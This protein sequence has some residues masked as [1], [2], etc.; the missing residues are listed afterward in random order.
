MTAATTP[1]L[2][3]V[4]EAGGVLDAL[5]AAVELRRRAVDSSELVPLLA[6]LH[7]GDA[8]ARAAAAYS[9]GRCPGAAVD[10]ALSRS[11]MSRDASVRNA[12]LLALSGRPSFPSAIPSLHRLAGRGGLGGMLA[13]LALEE[14]CADGRRPRASAVDFADTG[15]MSSRPSDGLRVA[16]VFLQ[17]R[18]DGALRDAGAG[19]GGGLATLVV[20]LSRALGR[21]PEIGHSAIITRAFADH[22]APA[23]HDLLHEPIGD[24]ASI[25]RIEFGPDGYLATAD[26]W[27]YRGEAEE[28][29]EA[30]FN[31]LMPL[32]VVHLRFADVGTFAAA[33]VCARLGIPVCFTV[34]AD[35]HVVIR[36]AER[37]GTL[38]RETFA[39]A[40]AGEHYLFRIHLVESMLEQA[41]GL[42]LFPRKD[43]AADVAELV[44]LGPR[45]APSQRVRTVAEGISLRTL[46]RT[47]RARGVEPEPAVLRDLKV[48]IG[49]L[50]RDRAGLPLL[51]SIGRFNR[52]KGF[53]RLLEAWAGDPELHA[54][55]N[56][57][58]IG[59]DLQHPTAEERVVMQELE[60]VAG[61][62]P[63][64]EQGLLLIGH[65]AHDD[66]ARLLH[67]ARSGLGDLVERGGMYACASA[68]EEFGLALLEAL[69]VGLPVV[70]PL[71][72]G[73]AT[74]I[75][76]GITG[77]LVDTTSIAE[78]RRGLKVAALLRH[79]DV[80]A[81]KAANLVRSRFS[82]DAMAGELA[83]LYLEIAGSRRLEVAA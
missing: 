73:P 81:A 38:T 42:V 61:R 9:V 45:T 8:L 24:R 77:A 40:D 31:R 68:K 44:G 28:A 71:A 19:D 58:I 60:G 48:A 63:G 32:D 80:R 33:R 69:A 55:F 59:G 37:S 11:L 13:V 36:N 83:A 7:H 75:E 6:L 15:T 52:V 57:V 29:L 14:W 82:V 78:L 23:I 18:V 66:V 49:A 62:H 16:Q 21:R 70:A 12:A 22:H 17:G 26:M 30:A 53:G 39:E 50:P 41:E 72:G 47:S 3:D 1:A 51:V 34:A 5:R 25:E 79:D 54:A 76:D 65:R 43:A 64:V 10:R 67:A 2:V 35:P 4:I 74:Y 27:S 20:H 56:L 46:D